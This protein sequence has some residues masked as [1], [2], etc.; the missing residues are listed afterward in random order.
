MVVSAGSRQGYHALLSG[1]HEQCLFVLLWLVSVCD[2]G[3]TRRE[4]RERRRVKRRRRMWRSD[5]DD[6]NGDKKMEE[7]NVMIYP[8]LNL[9]GNCIASFIDCICIS[10]GGKP[11]ISLLFGF[12]G[13]GAAQMI[14][15]SVWSHPRLPVLSSITTTIN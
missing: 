1:N 11:V 13:L 4:L 6:K 9:G 3:D 14:A 8:Q 12:S 5:N 2:D 10:P 15:Y 7:R